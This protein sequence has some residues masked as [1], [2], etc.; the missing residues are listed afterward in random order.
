[1]TTF[2]FYPLWLIK[3]VLASGLKKVGNIAGLFSYPYIR[4]NF[5]YQISSMILINMLICIPS[6][7]VSDEAGSVQGGNRTDLAHAT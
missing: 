3:L 7:C 5:T 6:R 1:M 4:V 2:Y